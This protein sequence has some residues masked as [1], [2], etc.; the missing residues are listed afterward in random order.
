M[1][2]KLNELSLTILGTFN[3]LIGKRAGENVALRLTNSSAGIIEVLKT[4]L[5]SNGD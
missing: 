4:Q 3:S 2:E 1:D 5:S